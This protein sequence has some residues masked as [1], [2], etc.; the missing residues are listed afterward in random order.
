M[1][2]FDNR[3]PRAAIHQPCDEVCILSGG[4]RGILPKQRKEVELRVRELVNK[5]VRVI[6]NRPSARDV[7]SNQQV[8]K[9]WRKKTQFTW[10]SGIHLFFFS[11][12]TVWEEGIS[13]ER[14]SPRKKTIRDRCTRNIQESMK[15]FC[16]G[17]SAC[18]FLDRCVTKLR[19]G[20]R[21]FVWQIKSNYYY[22]TFWRMSP[23]V[24]PRKAILRMTY[25]CFDVSFRRQKLGGFSP[26]L[27]N[28]QR[29]DVNLQN[30]T[31]D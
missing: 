12:C 16:C 17:I 18:K 21:D 3:I 19:F 4:I 8:V 30:A 6:I 13:T 9:L 5:V 29:N 7:S 26:S 22:L 28:V 25:G 2:T 20:K 11:L 27:R 24:P 14:N 23:D 10:L 1:G 31:N 15:L